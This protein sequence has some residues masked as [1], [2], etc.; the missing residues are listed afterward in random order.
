MLPGSCNL[1][2]QFIIR[3]SVTYDRMGPFDFFALGSLCVDAIQCFFFVETAF[4]HQ[5]FDLDFFR[6][7]RNPDAIT[8]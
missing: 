6:S 4:A 8:G 3:T 5:A 1:L 2:P 7:V